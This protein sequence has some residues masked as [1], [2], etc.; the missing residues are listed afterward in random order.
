MNP[1]IWRDMIK[2]PLIAVAVALVV[3]LI[4]IGVVLL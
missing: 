1:H 2:P 4:V 3:A